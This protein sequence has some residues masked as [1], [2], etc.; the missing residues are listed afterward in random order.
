MS[1]MTHSNFPVMGDSG[2]PSS[3]VNMSGNRSPYTQLQPKGGAAGEGGFGVPGGPRKATEVNAEVL[4]PLCKPQT[5][6]FWPNAANH[7]DTGRNTK[8][9]PS[10]AG[11][12]DFWSQ[13]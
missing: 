3:V 7:N 11:V 5:T 1:D 12:S 8:I 10:R 2:I 9:M 4:G 6:L 13:R